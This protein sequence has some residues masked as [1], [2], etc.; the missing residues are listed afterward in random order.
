[1]IFQKKDLLSSCMNIDRFKSLDWKDIIS[2][3]RFYYL[4]NDY[5]LTQI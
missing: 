1:M 2:T 3:S 4:V 5:F